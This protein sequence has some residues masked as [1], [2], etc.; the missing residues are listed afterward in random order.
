VT[1]SL[2]V[3]TPGH[4]V[5][6]QDGG[7]TGKR[8]WG[9]PP[10]GALDL[11]LLAAANSL[12]GN[13][14]TAAALEIPLTGPV[15]AA[16]R[17]PLAVALAGNVTA[18]H[19]RRDGSQ[20]LVP[21]WRAIELAPGDRFEVAMPRDG[22]AY[23]GVS[24]GIQTETLLGSRATTP[25]AGLGR[26]LAAGDLLPCGPVG[27]LRQSLPWQH[28]EGP[29][30]LLPGPQDDHF[31]KASRALLALDYFSLSSDCNRMGLRLQGA[32]LSHSAK[33]AEIVTEGVTPGAIQVPADGQP[34][35]LLNDAQTSGGYAK[36][37]C[38]ISADLPRLA[39][40]RPGQQILFRWVD[41]PAALEALRGL[42]RRFEDW[43]GRRLSGFIDDAAL[44]QHNLIS[45]VTSG[46][47][48]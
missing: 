25:T 39:H 26:P 10:S 2:E 43:R 42:H 22:I 48:L 14:A 21:A 16:V 27:A 29:I 46:E 19:C 33:G 28:D 35:I 18:L 45:G 1:A 7:R 23:L 6:V 44:Y 41:R 17:A 34:I 9:V 38:A 8:R 13:P 30:R 36:I 12:L 31:T 40:L 47:E 11:W 4:G 15:L 32:K 20:V 24:G 37:A 3:L 5:G